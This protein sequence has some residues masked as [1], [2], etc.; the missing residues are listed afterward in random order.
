MAMVEIVIPTIVCIMLG[1]LFLASFKVPREKHGERKP[2]YERVY[3]WS[4]LL[5][6]YHWLFAFSILALI[7]TG[8]YIGWPFTNTWNEASSQFT[9]AN[10]RWI[11]FIFGYLFTVA[12]IIRVYLYFFGNKYE[13]LWNMLPITPE[14]GKIAMQSQL[15]YAYISDY[16]PHIEGHNPGAGGGYLLTII[17]AIFQFITGF[18]LLYGDP[19]WAPAWVKP[20][21]NLGDMIFGTQQFARFIHH[22]L[23]WYFFIFAMIHIYMVAMN[24]IRNPEGLISSIFTGYKFFPVHEHKKH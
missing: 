19:S 23:N 21:W 7:I 3:V 17:L 9:M 14:Q 5:R 4:I 24:D 2:G 22:I 11:H 18:Y 1:L 12:V 20:F 13:K 10:M 8:L 16:H 6:F 15:W